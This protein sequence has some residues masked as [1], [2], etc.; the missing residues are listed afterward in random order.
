MVDI[1]V[2][3]RVLNEYLPLLVTGVQAKILKSFFN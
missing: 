3:Y 1:Y 2:F